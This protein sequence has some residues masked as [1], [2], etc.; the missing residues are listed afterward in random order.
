MTRCD[1]EQSL[2]SAYVDDELDPSACQ[3]VEE[4]LHTCPS[5]AAQ[6]Q[7]LKNL[8]EAF[9]TYPYPDLNSTELDRLHQ[10]LDEEV[11]APVLRLAGSLSVVAASVLIV[12]TAWLLELRSTQP[13][14]V[15]SPANVTLAPAPAWEQVATSLHVDAPVY[16]GGIGNPMDRTQ[17]ADA[18][19]AD[20]MLQGL[21][22][23]VPDLGGRHP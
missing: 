13:V 19:I 10:V 1:F 4:H 3:R 2:L 22:G 16:G 9:A 7:S 12:A 15:A 17:L 8:A 21:G 5:C 11:D 14:P 6:L 23:P 20:W 18:Q